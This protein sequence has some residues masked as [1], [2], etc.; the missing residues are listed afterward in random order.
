MVSKIAILDAIFEKRASN[1]LKSIASASTSS[2]ILISKLKLTRKQYYSRM[3]LLVQNGLVKRQRG[4]Y[5]LTALGKVIYSAQLNLEER[6]ENALNNYWKLKAIDSLDI[7][8]YPR[9][10]DNNVIS[11]LIDNEEIRSVLI[12]REKQPRLSVEQINSDKSSLVE[13]TSILARK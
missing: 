13:T 3:S 11:T 4:R 2:D 7:S 8:S 9:E 6:I 5:L 1:I 10:E 12:R